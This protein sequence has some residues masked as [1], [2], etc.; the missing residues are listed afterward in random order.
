MP[1]HVLNVPY[2]RSFLQRTVG[3][4]GRTE[5]GSTDGLWFDRCSS[6][7]T[8]FMRTPIDVVFIDRNNRVLQVS[9]NVQP[10]RLYVGCRGASSIVELAPGSIER[11]RISVG[12]MVNP[13]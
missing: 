3:L 7:H 6:I 10:W 1:E 12:D 13:A 11:L 4:I 5:L 9:P 2:A 8:L